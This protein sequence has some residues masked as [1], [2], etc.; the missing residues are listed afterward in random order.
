MKESVFEGYFLIV[1]Q[2]GN[3]LYA[4]YESSWCQKTDRKRFSTNNK[5]YV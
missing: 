4:Y 2:N 1:R 5:P 3:R